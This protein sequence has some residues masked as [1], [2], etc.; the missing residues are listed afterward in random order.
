MVDTPVQFG[1]NAK[2]TLPLS[3]S[4][5]PF[6]RFQVK[7]REAVCIP[8]G[9]TCESAA[10]AAPACSDARRVRLLSPTSRLPEAPYQKSVCSRPDREG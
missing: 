9:R 4:L 2:A 1:R 3:H 6:R 8:G 10:A 7:C 5:G